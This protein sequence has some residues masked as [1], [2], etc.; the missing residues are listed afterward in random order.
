MRLDKKRDIRNNI[1]W[2]LAVSAMILLITDIFTVIFVPEISE[3]HAYLYTFCAYMEFLTMWC[4]LLLVVLLFKK[5]R[6]ILNTLKRN[7]GRNNYSTLFLGFLIGFLLNLFCAL[8][9]LFNGN[10]HLEFQ[11]FH[12][13]PVLGLCAAVAVQSFAEEFL[14]R[15]FLY[16]R[17]LTATGKPFPAI[18][19]NSLFFALFHTFNDGVTMLALY[20]LLITGIFFSMVV[21]YSDSLW[22]AAGIHTTWNFTQ[23]ILLGLPN[24]GAVFPYSVMK[25]NKD[26]AASGFAYNTE[27]GLEGTILSSVLMTVCCVGIYFWQRKNRAYA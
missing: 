23:S 11:Q 15:G 7:S 13:L 19:L 26:L 14:C 9:A 12:L 24:S 25:L 5:N 20:D 2:I 6:S 4:S 21:Y 16:Q 27:F 8:T 1:I 22:M 18:F 3:S 10:I 17:L